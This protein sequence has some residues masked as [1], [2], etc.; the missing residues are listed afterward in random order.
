MPATRS[1]ISGERKTRPANRSSPPPTGKRESEGG[2]EKRADVGGG[3][4]GRQPEPQAMQG[5]MMLRV[6]EARRIP[7]PAGVSPFEAQWPSGPPVA[8]PQ[9][10]REQRKPC[11]WLPYAVLE[12]DKNELVIDALG[13]NASNPIWNY[14]ANLLLIPPLLAAS[15]DL[16]VAPRG[17]PRNP[18]DSD[19]DG[20]GPR[21]NPAFCSDVSRD[22][23]AVVSIFLRTSPPEAAKP[24][25]I[26]AGRGAVRGGR[27]PSRAAPSKQ[28]G[29]VFLG[30][31]CI[32]PDFV[33]GRVVDQWFPLSNLPAAPAVAG[34]SGHV[35]AVHVQ[36][37]FKRDSKQAPLSID[38]FDLLK[39]IGKGSFGKVG[40]DSR[41][42][43][44][45]ARSG[46]WGGIPISAVLQPHS[47][48]TSA[49]PS[50]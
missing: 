49:L 23:E 21:R 13:G 35:S 45:S 2:R 32:K 17:S 18:P 29:D 7:L 22:S 48:K 20:A 19:L 39:V 25:D 42:P 46:A 31:V 47:R 12:F 1:D 28:V 14:R 50:Q 15:S 43:G 3:G 33:D 38:S 36:F 27:N 5:L 6:C 11:W 26:G 34:S 24:A 9:Q 30:S 4:G 16:L 44:R 8:T 10:I 37:M 40:Y 41:P